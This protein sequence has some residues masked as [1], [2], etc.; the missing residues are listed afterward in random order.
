MAI[1]ECF[2]P[3][4]TEGTAYSLEANKPMH[5]KMVYNVNWNN[6]TI[7]ATSL[8]ARTQFDSSGGGN[9]RQVRTIHDKQ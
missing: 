9:F 4:G 3:V 6:R 5:V 7:S 2:E 1:W 8:C